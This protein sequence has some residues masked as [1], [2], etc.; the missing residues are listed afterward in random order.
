[1]FKFFSCVHPVHSYTFQVRVRQEVDGM[2]QEL[3]VMVMGVM[4]D[5]K[6]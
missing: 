4:A 5:H 1:M 3:K 6:K 2:S